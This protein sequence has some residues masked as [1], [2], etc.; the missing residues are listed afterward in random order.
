LGWKRKAKTEAATPAMDAEVST[1]VLAIDKLEHH[2]AGFTIDQY[3]GSSVQ[4]PKT[5]LR[6]QYRQS[7]TRSPR[8]RDGKHKVE[9]GTEISIICSSGLVKY[10]LL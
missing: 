9:L 8:D 7:S 2:E 1:E 6:Q 4:Y 5:L 3:Y 10:G